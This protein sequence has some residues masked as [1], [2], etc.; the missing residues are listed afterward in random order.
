M[1]VTLYLP[2]GTTSLGLFINAHP[3]DDEH[4]IVTTNALFDVHDKDVL[5]L[6]GDWTFSVRKEMEDE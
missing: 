1:K 3:N 6:D 2:D 5:S 4:H